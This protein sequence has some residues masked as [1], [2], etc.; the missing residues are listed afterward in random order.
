MT[1]LLS[2]SILAF[3]VSLDSFSVGLT[4]GLRQMKLPMLSVLFIMCCS[5]VA[6]LLA[7]WIGNTISALLAPE[8]AETL[9]GLLLI[10]IGLYALFQVYKKPSIYAPTLRQ[11]KVLMDV[12]LKRLGIAVHVLK[13][14]MAADLDDSGS[15]TGLEAVLLGVA[16]SLDAFGAGLGAALLGVSPWLLSLS[17][18]VMCGVFLTAG[19][20]C[21]ALLNHS[22]KL[23]RL[24]F[25]PGV[26]LICIGI[27]KL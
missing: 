27:W 20:W 6:I 7:M 21:G 2:L 4:Y 3:A 16:L 5:A 14:P 9:G 22:E 13:K 18:A 17:V 8:F 1:E 26:L 10:L 15:I 19:K 12:E 23:K 25:L 24:S 11:E